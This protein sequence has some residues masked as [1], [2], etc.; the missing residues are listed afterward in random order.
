MTTF[1]STKRVTAADIAR[2][3]GIS[4]A[5]VGF[6]LNSTPGQTIS[7][8]TRERVL[9]EAERLGYTPH[10]A[11]Q[12]LASGRS[13]IILLVLPDWPMDHSMREH[14]DVASQTLDAAGFSL[15]TMT[16]HPGGKARP[17]WES[18]HPDVVMG[19]VPFSQAQID[20][21]HAS[22][23]SRI[24]PP[25][26]GQVAPSDKLSFDE[27]PRLQVEHLLGRGRK[28][29]AYAASSDP[30]IA[31]LVS[32]RMDMAYSTAKRANAP[33]QSEFVDEGNVD[34]IVTRWVARGIDGVVAYN[35]DIAALVVRAAVRRGIAVPESLAVIGHDDSPIAHMYV[36]SLSTVRID[37]AG[38]GRYMAELA[39]SVATGTPAPAAGPETEATVVSRESS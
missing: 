39:L 9:A 11:A 33:M 8:A 10:R 30:R 20:A 27:G 14:L 38:L 24:V 21:L 7:P 23:I 18:L 25:Q 1:E 16:S 12:A 35:D 19:M 32:D 29:L 34:R 2:S 31:G 15:V 37:T 13:R 4:R 26:P 5:T 28:Q 36:P 3:L 22:G 6:V 17:L